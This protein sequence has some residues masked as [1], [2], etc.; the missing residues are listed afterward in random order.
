[1]TEA[2]QQR[3]GLESRMSAWSSDD[4]IALAVRDD[5]GHINLRGSPEDAAFVEAAGKALGQA[6]PTEANTI[7]EGDLT[8]FWLGPDEWLV[9][10][11]RDETLAL[12]STL[13]ESL[14]EQHFAVNIVSGGQLALALSGHRVRELMAKGC[15]LDFHPKAFRR[16]QCA[17]SG[18]AK[19]GVLIGCVSYEEDFLIVVRRSF[20]DYL[21][22]WL[23]H[24]S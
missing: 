6:L 7:S 24:V 4:G 8:I 22:S 19:A 10:A 21:L 20:S 14:K 12:A 1:M 18:L 15:T 9:L 16:G 11:P 2:L 23:M 5:L 3:H 17:Q 13:E